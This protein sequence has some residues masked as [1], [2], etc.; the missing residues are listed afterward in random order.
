VISLMAAASNAWPEW[1]ALSYH[2][3]MG[4]ALPASAR[5]ARCSRDMVAESRSYARSGTAAGHAPA[6]LQSV[7]GCQG[8]RTRSPG[9]DAERNACVTRVWHKPKT[10]CAA[11]RLPTRAGGAAAGPTSLLPALSPP[12]P[13]PRTLTSPGRCPGRCPR[14]SWRPPCRWRRWWWCRPPTPCR[15]PPRRRSQSRHLR[16]EAAGSV[17]PPLRTTH[18][19]STPVRF[20]IVLWAG[21][22]VGVP[23]IADAR[24]AGTTPPC[25]LPRRGPTSW[26]AAEKSRAGPPPGAPPLQ[27]Q[28]RP[29]LEATRR[30]GVGRR[31][32]PAQ[33]PVATGSSWQRAARSRAALRRPSP[34]RTVGPALALALALARHVYLLQERAQQLLRHQLR[35]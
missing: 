9:E 7:Q 28:L 21:G 33:L 14:W 27:P 3:L 19:P 12:P 2:R 15:C 5:R 24:A 10:S 32:R 16:A 8:A 6:T 17:S 26:R 11:G 31:P 18:A 35:P 25:R 29:A 30:A 1:L 34:A 22:W 4:P 20:N 13:T 23:V